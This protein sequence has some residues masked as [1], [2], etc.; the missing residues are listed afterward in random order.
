MTYGTEEEEEEWGVIVYFMQ[1]RFQ[2]AWLETV[3]SSRVST[4]SE[5]PAQLLS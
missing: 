3:T 5:T 2:S 1:P 4:Q